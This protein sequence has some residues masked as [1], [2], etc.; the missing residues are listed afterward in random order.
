MTIRS[1]SWN[2]WAA[3]G[4]GTRCGEVCLQVL[5]GSSFLTGRSSSWSQFGRMQTMSR[6]LA[7]PF[8]LQDTSASFRKFEFSPDASPCQNQIFLCSG[9]RVYGLYCIQK[10]ILCRVMVW[11]NRMDVKNPA[12]CTLLVDI[13]WRDI[14]LANSHWLGKKIRYERMKSKR[15][16]W[17]LYVFSFRSH[18]QLERHAYAMCKKLDVA[19]NPIYGKVIATGHD[20]MYRKLEEEGPGPKKM[21]KTS[22]VLFWKTEDYFFGTS[23][24]SRHSQ[25]SC[26]Y[27]KKRGILIRRCNEYMSFGDTHPWTTYERQCQCH[28]Y[29]KYYAIH[30]N[31]YTDF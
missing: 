9:R 2:T 18:R 7:C 29:Y 22:V 14:V 24:H 4:E 10:N 6:I 12:A 1:E 23:D 13:N 19:W 11:V 28:S 3:W 27:V 26:N 30:P 15:L 31:E 21:Q 20:P 5:W 25:N 17:S 8:L 16:N